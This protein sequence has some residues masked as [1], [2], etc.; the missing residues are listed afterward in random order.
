V[1]ASGVTSPPDHRKTGG[2]VSERDSEEAALAF[3]LRLDPA[4]Q[5]AVYEQFGEVLAVPR[6]EQF[7]NRRVS[8]VARALREAKRLLGKSPS[9][10]EY[11]QLRRAHPE[12]EWP[13]EQS[14]TRW[15]GLRGWNNALVRM[16]LEAVV[17]GDVIETPGPQSYR[18]DEVIGALRDCAS[19]LGYVPSYNDSFG[20]VRRP[21]VEARPGRR[22]RS[23]QPFN[24]IF[25][26]FREARLAA[27]L[28]ENELAAPTVHE[29]IRLPKW[30]TDPEEV[31]R[32]IRLVAKRVNGPMTAARYERER[33]ALFAETKAARRPVALASSATIYRHFR[34]WSAALEAARIFDDRGEQQPSGLLP[35][36]FGSSA[37]S[38]C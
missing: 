9:V 29:I 11:E 25:G 3:L 5:H 22:P 32:H 36:A 27:G 15:L 24:R 28:V 1:A 6:N 2:R 12:W 10:R 4:V 30:G 34:Y 7:A 35:R 18:P 26:S 21:D 14:V 38:R 31:L 16:G 19:E 20:W 33:R 13:S 8:R 23:F 37:T 17:E